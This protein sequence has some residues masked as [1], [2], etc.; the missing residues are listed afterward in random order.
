MA[1]EGVTCEEDGAVTL[2][3]RAH[4]RLRAMIADG[5]LRVGDRLTES[6]VSR[7]FGISRSPAREALALLA[8]DGLIAE[9]QGRGYEVVGQ[10]ADPGAS[11]VA[12]IDEER[13]A[14]AP[15]W[16]RIYATLEQ[17]IL[18]RVL[19]GSVR[20]SDRQLAEHFGVSRTVTR[21]LLAR[22]HGLGIVAKSRTGHWVAPQVRPQ[23][24]R[25]LFELRS[26]LEPEALIRAAPMLDD[27]LVNGALAQVE[28]AVASA[29]TASADFD[30]AETNLHIVIL[31]ACPNAE[32]VAALRQ[33]HLL[34]APTRYLV[35][36]VLGL[37]SDLI[38]AA[39]AEHLEVLTALAGRDWQRAA[40]LL[41]NHV[42]LASSRWMQ[43][44][45]LAEQAPL[46]DLPSYLDFHQDGG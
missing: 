6:H 26:I 27:A 3:G 8:F 17:E 20:I 43:R 31:G 15:Q 22:M 14:S 38:E 13:I 21:D 11:R 9:R 7:S 39:L 1:K 5:R 37:P 19:L 45:R 23:R 32:I 44:F 42:Q 24:I 10:G 36:P 33:A 29:P 35:D 4:A 40:D 16:Q 2:R 34:F 41:R 46:P 12:Q 18:T 25:D 30:R 28:G